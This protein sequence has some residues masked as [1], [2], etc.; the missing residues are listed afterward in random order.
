MN[1]GG[2]SKQDPTFLCRLIARMLAFGRRP[3]SITRHPL[4][5]LPPCFSLPRSLP[6]SLFFSHHH[7]CRTSKNTDF[8]SLKISSLRSEKGG[9]GLFDSICCCCRFHF[10][11]L[12]AP[13]PLFFL[14]YQC[15]PPR[16]SRPTCCSFLLPPPPTLSHFH[17]QILRYFHFFIFPPSLFPALKCVCFYVKLA[18]QKCT[19][20]FAVCQNRLQAKFKT[21]LLVLALRSPCQDRHCVI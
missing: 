2:G 8:V 13:N 19:C 14:F 4:S 16:R 5:P 7:V 9:G 12:F 6:L 21:L 1:H 11:F 10:I 15:W 17:I 3:Q 20:E 18:G